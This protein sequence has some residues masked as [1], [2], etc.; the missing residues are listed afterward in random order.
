MLKLILKKVRGWLEMKKF[1]RHLTSVVVSESD[2]K[3]IGPAMENLPVGV[4]GRGFAAIVPISMK[5]V[6]AKEKP[7]GTSW[8][9]MIRET[10][11]YLFFI[12]VNP[13]IKDPKPIKEEVINRL[14]EALRFSWCYGGDMQFD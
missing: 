3:L 6:E 7:G 11:I 13:D 12:V 5:N 1:K 14:K 10:P 4:Y 8:E 9:E 2:C